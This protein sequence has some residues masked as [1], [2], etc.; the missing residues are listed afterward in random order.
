MLVLIILM[1]KNVVCIHVFVCIL[2]QSYLNHILSSVLDITLVDLPGICKN[3]V[4]DQP[5]DIEQQTTDLAMSY[6]R[7]QHCIILAVSPAS[8]DPQNSEA[9]KIARIVDPNGTFY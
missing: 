5:H 7:D 3:P 6:V 9:M 2:Q 1:P 4:E 8:D